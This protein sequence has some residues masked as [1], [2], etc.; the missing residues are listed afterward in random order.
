MSFLSFLRVPKIN[1]NILQDSTRKRIA[2]TFRKT[3][4]VYNHKVKP[5]NY[6]KNPHAIDLKLQENLKKNK[7]N[8][9]RK[10]RQIEN[11]SLKPFGQHSS[12]GGF[13]V[14]YSRIPKIDIPNYEE[15]IV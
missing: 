4:G 6:Y 14:D 3:L 1:N 12:K 11:L 15:S 5:S 7:D 13:K 8:G 9:V 10:L 2:L